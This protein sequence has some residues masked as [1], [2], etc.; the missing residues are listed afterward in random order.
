[1]LA[2]NLHF[3][4]ARSKA[5]ELWPRLTPS[6]QRPCFAELEIIIILLRFETAKKDCGGAARRRDS[7]VRRLIPGAKSCREAT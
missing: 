5:A 1:M 7:R 2:E 4:P 3:L 6:N